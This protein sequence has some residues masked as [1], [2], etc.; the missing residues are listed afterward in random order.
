M[1]EENRLGREDFFYHH[2]HFLDRFRMDPK[3]E[4]LEK[5]PVWDESIDVVWYA[6]TAATVQKLANDMGYPVPIWTKKKQYKLESPYFQG[7]AEDDF[8]I[9]LLLSTPAEF[10]SHNIFVLPNVLDR[11]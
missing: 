2:G 8:R 1:I 3:M 6:Y 9:V 4:F 11:L 5:E 7:N 10:M